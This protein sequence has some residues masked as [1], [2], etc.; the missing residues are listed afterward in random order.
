MAYVTYLKSPFRSNVNTEIKW[1]ISWGIF[2]I[3]IT[4]LHLS[5]R[6]L[7]ENHSP[8][9]DELWILKMH[10]RI[11][12]LQ[13]QEK[14]RT[15]LYGE[16]LQVGQSR[17]R[18]QIFWKY[19]E[20]PKNGDRHATTKK[21]PLNLKCQSSHGTENP[22][23]GST[24]RIWTLQAKISCPELLNPFRFVLTSVKILCSKL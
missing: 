10:D 20:I 18:T 2:T 22:S 16:N 17:A 8:V 19:S 13:K 9:L 15:K 4:L 6:E 1:L 3:S 11:I 21:H 7:L 5:Y 23:K 14:K 24:S 12:K